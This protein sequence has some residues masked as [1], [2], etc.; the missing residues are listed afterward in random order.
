MVLQNASYLLLLSAVLS[1]GLALLAARRRPLL[2]TPA[3]ISLASAAGLW[4]VAEFLSRTSSSFE[5]ASFWLALGTL[6]ASIVPV[7]AVT[8]TLQYIGR[9]R[10]LT[11]WA[12]ML[13]LVEPVLTAV[14]VWTN[15]STRW[16][17]MR[18]EMAGE[19]S[20]SLV[21]TPGVWGMVHGVYGYS[22]CAAATVLFL[23]WLLRSKRS[24]YGSRF[25]LL[26]AA[27]LPWIAKGVTALRLEPPGAVELTPVGLFLSCA[28]LFLAQ[29]R[30]RLPGLLAT[31]AQAVFGGS[32]DLVI[33]LDSSDR[34][35]HLNPAAERATALVSRNVSGRAIADVMPDSDL[36]HAL[37]GGRPAGAPVTIGSG[38]AS[39]SYDLHLVPLYG[40][41]G[42]AAGRML[43]LRDATARRRTD[44]VMAALARTE[45]LYMAARSLITPNQPHEV[46]QVTAE[47][48]SRALPAS[49]VEV[50]AFNSDVTRIVDWAQAPA[51]AAGETEPAIEET[52]TGLT[53]WVIERNQPILTLKG[54][55]DSRETTEEQRRRLENDTGSQ[56]IAP[57][58]VDGRVVGLLVATN[59]RSERDFARA[60]MH[61][62]TGLAN[63]AVFAYE[64]ACAV[65][66]LGEQLSLY[67]DVV[68]DQDELVCRRQAD[69]TISFANEA[70][71]AF[72]G[73]RADEVV[74]CLYY[75]ST[76]PEEQTNLQEELAMLSPDNP[77]ISLESRVLAPDG[78]VRWMRSRVRG[79][80][81]AQG[82][83][84]SSQE[85]STEVTHQKEDEKTLR[86]SELKHR[87]LLDSIASPLLALRPD[88]TI[89]YCNDA[90]AAMT[91]RS[92]SDLSSQNV[93]EVLPALAE[94]TLWET[95]RRAQETGTAGEVEG[96]LAGRFWYARVNPTPWGVLAAAE[97]IT[98]LV[99]ARDKAL[100]ASR[101]KSE[102]LATMSH[103]VRT[104]MNAI[105]GMTE[106][107]LDMPLNPEQRDFA[108]VVLEQTNSLLLMIENI[109]DY[110]KMEA[111]RLELEPKDFQLLE[112]V[113][114]VID[115]LAPMLRDKDVRILTQI[116][117]EIPSWLRGD[118][119]R[120]KQVLV[121][122]VGNACKFTEKGQ[123]FIHAALESQGAQHAT[124]RFEV[125]DTGVGIP[126]AALGRLFEP[127]TQ[128]DSSSTRKYGGAG[129]GLAIS[130]RL[131]ELMGGQIELT[132][133]V[134][135]G[136]SVWFTATFQ[137]SAAPDLAVLEPDLQGL[138]VLIVD[139]A[140]DE[141]QMLAGHLS[142]WGMQTESA[143]GHELALQLLGDAASAGR[144]YDAVLVAHDP[145]AVDSFV[146]QRG[147]AESASLASTSVVLLAGPSVTTPAGAPPQ[148][149]FEAVLPTP[150]EPPAL[151]NALVDVTL[152]LPRVRTTRLPSSTRGQA[153]RLILLAEDNPTT[154][155]MVLLQ[156]QRLGYSAHTVSDGRQAVNAVAVAP[157]AYAAILM[158]CQ[159][160]GLDGF[161]ATRALRESSGEDGRRIP[162]VALTAYSTEQ[163]RQKCL[164]SGM[165][166][167]ISKPVTRERLREVL[168]RWIP[169]EARPGSPD[170]G[171]SALPSD[172]A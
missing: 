92:A 15:A 93:L 144:P 7:A 149:L 73:Q 167:Y 37:A 126:A 16:M 143:D 32:S 12:R 134:G 50:V 99:Q 6:A 98:E 128:A 146:L 33:V 72:Y 159:M 119:L 85:V 25:V 123:I 124:I 114:G 22:L 112:L 55:P 137:P 106:L 69:G 136:T 4:A 65:S 87:V 165:D 138:R 105:V 60:D 53:G 76:P 168:E 130:R 10:L 141:A 63:Q 3:P 140:P 2:S 14:A 157:S 117:P 75:P 139:S 147:L 169:S 30:S 120:L 31:A 82:C 67:K 26:V 158:D 46:L 42:R 56:I 20:S 8:L 104:P 122:L 154:Q 155:T 23:S 115:L 51:S 40:A 142:S 13:L 38:P 95:F 18:L 150:I 125:S 54:V 49:R 11:R 170:S 162:I 34:L 171:P 90:F 145:P 48:V 160:P 78:S 81:D 19:T 58:A 71:C 36:V 77:E 107:L 52:K 131:V 91:G 116:A 43:M 83:L 88:S 109:L 108:H 24:I 127:F 29:A 39:R 132:S 89:L 166:D 100:D 129:L 64:R 70:Y 153:P 74:S 5:L 152:G 1:L 101:L 68:R 61:L 110:S 121:N 94:S 62:V 118:S 86:E 28:L 17:W 35:A 27:L 164:A 66:S 163:D 103:E 41:S 156:L 45:R 57:L 47:T 9:G 161:A 151:F 80:F 79:T 97:D 113:R 84:V 59:R 135:K 133:E 102:F 21:A 44:E 96:E 148:D 172:E 111:G